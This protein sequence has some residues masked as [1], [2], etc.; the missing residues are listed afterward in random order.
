MEIMIFSGSEDSANSDLALASESTSHCL[1]PSGGE[2]VAA[3]HTAAAGGLA[4][5]GAGVAEAGFQV[6][7]LLLPESTLAA[8]EPAAGPR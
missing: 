7:W 1:S 6:H 3:R 8:S 4:L 5:L 2:V